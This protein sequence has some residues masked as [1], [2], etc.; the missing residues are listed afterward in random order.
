MS[1]PRS[2]LIASTSRGSSTY[3]LAP[4]TSH[5]TRPTPSPPATSAQQRYSLRL[6]KTRSTETAPVGI[7]FATVQGLRSSAKNLAPT[8]GLPRH[9]NERLVVAGRAYTRLPA[10]RIPRVCAHVER[11]AVPSSRRVQAVV[12]APATSYSMDGQVSE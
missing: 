6:G 3:C 1:S 8:G 5:G 7:T 10:N 2:T 11:D 4:F 9:S 12:R